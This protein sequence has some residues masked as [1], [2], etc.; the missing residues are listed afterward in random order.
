MSGRDIKAQRFRDLH[1]GEPFVI[2]GAQRI[3]VG[4]AFTGPAV[5][6][7]VAAASAIRERGDFLQLGSK[8][9]LDDWFAPGA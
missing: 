8:H 7:A 5:N 2:P 9:W 4:G 3:S 6:A 1:A